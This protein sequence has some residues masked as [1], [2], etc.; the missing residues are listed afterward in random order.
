M[1]SDIKNHGPGFDYFLNTPCNDW[2]ALQYHEFWKISNLG[3]GKAIVTRSFSKQIQRIKEYGTEEER[4]NSIRL[5]NQFT[6]SIIS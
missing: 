1:L 5:E 3:L 6:V 2:D 4:K